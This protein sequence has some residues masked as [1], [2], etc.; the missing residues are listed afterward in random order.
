MTVGCS[1]ATPLSLIIRAK[2]TRHLEP[3]AV[4]SVLFTVVCS[5]RLMFRHYALTGKETILLE[6]QPPRWGEASWEMIRRAL[7]EHWVAAA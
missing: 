4:L 6:G 1:H 2:H 3:G 7:L 5:L